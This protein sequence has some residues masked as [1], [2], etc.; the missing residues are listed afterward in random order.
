MKLM[1]WIEE[2][3]KIFRSCSPETQLDLYR[4]NP[5]TAAPMLRALAGTPG[6]VQSEMS[7]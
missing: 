2:T 5:D 3:A 1:V 7:P 4:S 6:W